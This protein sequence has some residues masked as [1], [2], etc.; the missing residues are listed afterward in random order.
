MKKTFLFL[1][2]IGI[3]A[4]L[5][6]CEK[7]KDALF[8]PF[9]SPLNADVQ[10]SPSAVGNTANLGSTVVNYDLNAE[11]SKATSGAF[12][13]SIIT[14]MYI[15]QIAISLSN[16]DAANNLS[17]FESVNVEIS[18]G[19]GA[20]IVLGPYPVPATV[21][22]SHTITVEN[23]PNIRPFFNG[24]TVTFALLG[25]TKTATTKTLNAR[26]GATIKFDR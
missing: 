3:A 16:A 13:G 25:K 24:S 9:E 4:V 10:I 22:S 14:K 20:P 15:N 7:A 17:N 11:V 8:K 26:I 5:P 2:V 21:T 18:S 23:S 12:D 19:P 6:S 1:A